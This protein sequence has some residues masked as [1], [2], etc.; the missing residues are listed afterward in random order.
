MSSQWNCGSN[1]ATVSDIEKIN[2]PLEVIH[3]VTNLDQQ[4]V[5][6]IFWSDPTDS[7]VDIQL[8]STRDPT[9]VGNIVKFVS[10]RVEEF[11]KNNNL[12]LILR[13][14]EFVMDGFER[15]SGGK[16]ITIF[17]A[18]DYCGKHKNA[19]AILF[20]TKN[21]MIKPYLIYPKE[22]PN[23]NWDNTEETLK[24]RPPTRNRQGSVND[25]GRKVS[26]NS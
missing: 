12:T 1:I 26:F 18:T 16:L 2:K 8:N 24:L 11:L 21:F 7:D 5:V 23:K 10:D 14:H 13:A 4:L 19:D 6:D 9:G 22:C 25:L 20:L 3:E 17:S 15:F